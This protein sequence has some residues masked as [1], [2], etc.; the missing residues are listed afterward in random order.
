[1]VKQPT[2]ELFED[3]YRESGANSKGEFIS[4]L[5]EKYTSPDEVKTIEKTVEIP[6]QLPENTI[7]LKLTQAQRKIFEN[8]FFTEVCRD[9]IIKY[10]ERFNENY[11]GI[12]PTLETTE[13]K[14]TKEELISKYLVFFM[15]A[16]IVQG[17]GDYIP[18]KPTKSEIREIAYYFANKK[19]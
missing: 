12:F 19:N 8:M 15:I 11:P 2:K 7:P 5:L 17:S 10:A 18:M 16:T 3:C 6:A 13:G 9:Q 4:W 14:L 1:M